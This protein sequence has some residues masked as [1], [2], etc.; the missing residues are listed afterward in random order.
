MF[1]R[2]NTVSKCQLLVGIAGMQ[3]ILTEQPFQA[4]LYRRDFGRWTIIW[5]QP[6]VI[7]VFD[8]YVLA[9][10]SI[11][12]K[13]MINLLNIFGYGLHFSSRQEPG[14]IADF[15]RTFLISIVEAI[16]ITGI[17][18]LMVQANVFDEK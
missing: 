6:F 3:S 10:S 14:I 4:D 2:Q 12:L 15:R 11:Y 1:E 16:Y 18:C 17:L 8:D 7:I 13:L 5:I 9:I